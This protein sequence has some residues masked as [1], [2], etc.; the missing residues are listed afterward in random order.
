MI[1]DGI[2]HIVTSHPATAALIG[3]KCYPALGVPA[4]TA[5]PYVTYQLVAGGRETHQTAQS[6]LREMRYQFDCVAATRTAA[7]A[8]AEAVKEAAAYYRGMVPTGETIRTIYMEVEMS[9]PDAPT[10]GS[11]RGPQRVVLDFVIWFVPA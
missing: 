7:D 8:L 6:D 2:F 11:Q 1:E 4:N 3:R 10:D 5:A 9:E